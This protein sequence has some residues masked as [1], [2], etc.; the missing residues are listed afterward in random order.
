VGSNPTSSAKPAPRPA[1]EAVESLMGFARAFREYAA[2][3]CAWSEL[4][5]LPTMSN[6]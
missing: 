2:S 3:G 5:R 4:R 1:A 6:G